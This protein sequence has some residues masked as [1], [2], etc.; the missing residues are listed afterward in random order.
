MY[1]E[2]HMT[3]IDVRI[4]VIT[5]KTGTYSNSSDITEFEPNHNKLPEQCR[6]RPNQNGY[7]EITFT[8]KAD[9][10]NGYIT[11]RF[12]P[13]DSTSVSKVTPAA[14][15]Y[16][17]YSQVKLEKGT[18]PTDWTPAPE[19]VE[20]TTTTMQNAIERLSVQPH[21]ELLCMGKQLYI[22]CD[23]GYIKSTDSVTFFRYVRSH[24]R[25][26]PKNS[27]T[28]YRCII[29]WKVPIRSDEEA[30]KLILNKADTSLILKGF[31]DKDV[32]MVGRYVK[33]LLGHIYT[34][35][36]KG[37]IDIFKTT[38]ITDNGDDKKFLLFDKKCGIRIKRD[39]EW[40]TDYLPFM[41]RKTKD[42]QGGYDYGIGRWRR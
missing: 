25:Y 19:D 35:V 14:N 22:V 9:T 13:T 15:D 32:Y 3:N 1:I 10:V 24:N 11:T 40:I 18:V 5:S 21:V 23:K 36:F 2:N 28:K 39:G 27:S 30:V 20:A 16:I 33:T 12:S 38:E 4:Y 41:A 7:S 17:N 34:D 26:K 8:T 31:K 29:G 42:G 6:I 37:I